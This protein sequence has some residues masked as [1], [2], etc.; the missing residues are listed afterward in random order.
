MIE[1][2]LALERLYSHRGQVTKALY[3]LGKAVEIAP[4]D[5]T[6][7]YRLSVIYRKLGRI[8]E[9]EKEMQLFEKAK[10]QEKRR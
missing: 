9:A 1:A 10:T 8:Q 3:H 7:H 6:P 5:A 4:E 2:H